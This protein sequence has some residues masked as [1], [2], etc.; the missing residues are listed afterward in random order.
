VVDDLERSARQADIISCATMTRTP[1]IRG[2]WL[3]AGGHV[4]LV[5][6]YNLD[7]RETDDEV[8]RRARVFVDT[9]AALTEGG[10]VAVALR[11]GGI[12]PSHVLGDLAA[13][14]AGR[15]QGRATAS[16]ITLVKSIGVAIED[17]AAA[18]AVWEAV[19]SGK[20]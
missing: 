10:D 13:L 2:A 17:L 7:M 8:L 16:D 19:S 9:Q 20:G 1:L 18:V 14:V 15:V 12:E 3:K 6:A 5:G 11:D 4:D